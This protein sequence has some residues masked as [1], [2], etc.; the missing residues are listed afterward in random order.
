VGISSTAQ[1]DARPGSGTL[2]DEA[3][4]GVGDGAID[5][6]GRGVGEGVEVDGGA[7]GL[8][9]AGATVIVGA[10]VEVAVTGGGVQVSARNA[11]ITKR[12]GPMA[13]RRVS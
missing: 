1:Y 12:S 13:A 11:Q 2:G 4:V 6:L 7:V 8:A 5:G 3:A 10:G 9:V